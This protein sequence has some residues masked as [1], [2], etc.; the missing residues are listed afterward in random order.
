MNDNTSG[1]Y[2]YPRWPLIKKTFQCIYWWITGIIIVNLPIGYWK[3]LGAILILTGL[4][5]WH[6]KV[7]KKWSYIIQLNEESIQ[8]G[9]LSYPWDQMKHIAV[10][11][12][13]ERRVLHLQG[14]IKNST[15]HLHIRD[16]LVHFDQLAEE[17][18]AN[19]NYATQSSSGSIDSNSA[20]KT[21]G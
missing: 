21:E 17:C 5:I 14:N 2:H 3:W 8:I 16:G 13:G 7:H 15:Y 1:I 9:A 6:F 10:E 11:R 12:I 4:A 18:L 20:T 19:F